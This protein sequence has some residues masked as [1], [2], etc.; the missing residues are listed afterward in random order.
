M[1]PEQA[2]GLFPLGLGLAMEDEPS[3]LSSIQNL[4]IIA[5]DILFDQF[6]CLEGLVH[7]ANS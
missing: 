5:I 2:L 6:D 1:C 4:I 3:E 7:I